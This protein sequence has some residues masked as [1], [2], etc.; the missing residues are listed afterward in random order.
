MTLKVS[1]E[2]EGEREER[3]RERENKKTIEQPFFMVDAFFSL[4]FSLS[5]LF[6]LP[7]LFFFSHLPMPEKFDLTPEERAV[8]NECQ[9]TAFNR[10]VFGSAVAA[11]CGALCEKMKER[12]RTSLSFLLFFLLSP[13][14][15]CLLLPSVSFSSDP[16][17]LV[18]TYSSSIPCPVSETVS[19]T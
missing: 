14:S 8:L 9:S 17:R 5:F 12:K 13:P 18:Y 16:R 3:E 11:T 7:F 2:S 6:F 19:K 1:R 15:F 10:G 4:H